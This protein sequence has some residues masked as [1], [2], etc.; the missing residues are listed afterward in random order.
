MKLSS[1]IKQNHFLRECR[2]GVALM[3]ALV[4]MFTSC[5][6]ENG[7]SSRFNL[8]YLAV[9]MEKDGKW[10]IVDADGKI[11]VDNEYAAGDVISRVY[12]DG[13]YWVKS[14]DKYRLFS[15]DSPK[16]P[17][18][19]EEYDSVTLFADGRAFVSHTGEPIQM[20]DNK[21]KVVLTLPRDVKSINCF[22]NGLARFKDSKD[23]YGY[24]NTD[25]KTV[26]EAKYNYAI[27]FNNGHACVKE[28]EDGKWIIID[29]KGNKTGEID[30][31]HKVK[32]DGTI[33]EILDVYDNESEIL[34]FVDYNG[35][36]VIKPQKD[37]V[38]TFGY[39]S[40]YCV[41]YTKDSEKGVINKAGEFI[42]R[43]GKYDFIY[44]I[45]SESGKFIV[46]SG[47]KWGLVD[48]DDNK[49]VDFVYDG[50]YMYTLG[51][52]YI[53]RDGSTWVLVDKDGKER[54]DISFYDFGGTRRLT[55]VTFTDIKAG[56]EALVS[57]LSPTGG[58]KPLNGKTDIADIAA[59]YK[60][61]PSEE[62]MTTKFQVAESKAGDWNV[63]VE[64][65]F[66]HQAAINLTHVETVSDGW[67]S[68]DKIVD[69]GIGWNP[70][71]N[72]GSVHLTVDITE[73]DVA[74]V[75]AAV[76]KAFVAKGFKAGG[77]DGKT[78]EVK[79]AD[80]RYMCIML[81]GSTT[82]NQLLLVCFPDLMYSEINTDY[83]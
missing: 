39:I 55:T 32:T 79:K 44:P 10:S 14:G 15:I 12:D 35:E 9:Q 20:I 74:D 31:R 64:L 38:N 24:M 37:F 57:Q 1:T 30:K 3:A 68:E 6:K 27:D 81:W 51:D 76:I 26:V 71:A 21:G 47:D 73:G 23:K 4:C 7:S 49:L 22:F 33:S 28:T 50:I 46:M 63:K 72:L 61:T 62:Y 52:N 53:A 19:K 80:G 78:L 70:E 13:I 58:Y 36:T 75:E 8:E 56:V 82:N 5:D 48:K 43:A 40:D 59:I 11:V 34:S 69:D 2:L 65:D 83:E 18:T 67:F 54:K 45:L 60:L 66:Y 42:I 29:T 77:D 16:M 17:L 41:V 25:G